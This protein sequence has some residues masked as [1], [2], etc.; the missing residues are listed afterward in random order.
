MTEAIHARKSAS[1]VAAPGKREFVG[2][3]R[4]ATHAESVD[5]RQGRNTSG[6]QAAGRPVRRSAATSGRGNLKGLNFINCIKSYYILYS[7]IFYYILLHSIGITRPS[8]SGL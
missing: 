4:I 6:P 5:M 2:L 8:P 3:Y 1:L 7:S